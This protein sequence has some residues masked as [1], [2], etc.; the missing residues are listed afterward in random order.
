MKT[1]LLAQNDSLVIENLKAD[2]GRSVENLTHSVTFP[3]DVDGAILPICCIETL[4]SDS[5]EINVE[6]LLRQL[7]PLKVPLMTTLRLNTAFYYCD[8]RLAWKK[9]ERF[10]TGGRSG[11]EIYDIPRCGNYIK[12]K[13]DNP[14]KLDL[15]DLNTVTEASVNYTGQKYSSCLHTYFGISLNHSISSE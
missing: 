10:M 5:F 3:I 9:W 14:D 13:T 6:C 15:L 1:N 4:P 2:I 11:N 12:T 8:N 7:S